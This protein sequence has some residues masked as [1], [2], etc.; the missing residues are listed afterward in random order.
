MFEFSLSKGKIVCWALVVLLFSAFAVS[1]LQAQVNTAVLSG[2]AMDTTGAVVAGAQIQ[3]TDVGTG[4]SYAGTTDGAGRYT[5]P[6]MPIGTYNVSAQKSRLPEIGADRDRTDHR[7]APGAGLYT[8]GGP[9]RRKW[10]R[11]MAKLPPWTPPRPQWASWFR[12]PR[13]R[14]CR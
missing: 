13:W 8:Q 4:I 3:A 7:R 5:L 12:Q 9:Y 14:T 6:E 11:C 2:T 10:S 1:N